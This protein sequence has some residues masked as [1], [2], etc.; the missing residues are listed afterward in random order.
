VQRGLVVQSPPEGLRE[1]RDV[2]ER[3]V[4]LRSPRALVVEQRMERLRRA[5]ELSYP[6]PTSLRDD[7]RRRNFR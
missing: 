4:P 7:K 5:P 6:R 1:L 2:H 3:D